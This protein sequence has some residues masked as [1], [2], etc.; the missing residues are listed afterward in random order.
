MSLR[1]GARTLVHI[2]CPEE[3]RPPSPLFVMFISDFTVSL[4]YV[5]ATSCTPVFGGRHSTANRT[6]WFR[7]SV[8]GSRLKFRATE[9]HQY[10]NG[11]QR[12]A[13][14]HTAV[15]AMSDGSP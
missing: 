14:L 8:R 4:G 13:V 12:S 9:T 15:V 10:C 1:W 7:R 11:A 2:S 6:F 3:K 5:Y